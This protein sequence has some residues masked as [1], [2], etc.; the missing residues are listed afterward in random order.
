MQSIVIVLAA[1]IIIRW[2]DKTYPQ[3]VHLQSIVYAITGL[4]ILAIWGNFFKGILKNRSV[5]RSQRGDKP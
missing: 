1:W 2:L 4:A 5:N 3:A